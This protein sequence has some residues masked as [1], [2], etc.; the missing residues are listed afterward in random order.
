[1]SANVGFD[2][3]LTFINCQIQPS[4]GRS[5][6]P[7]AESQWRAIT[8]S[9]QTGSGA[10]VL[11]GQLADELQRLLPG[12]GRPWTVFDRNLVEKVLE[13][14]HLPTRLAQFM[15]EDRVP[16]M[17]DAIDELL[18]LHPSSWTLVRQTSETILRLV[19]LG[20]VILIG[21]GSSIVTRTLEH[22]LH[23]RLVAP[24]ARRVENLQKWRNL[25]H[26]AALDLIQR[27][28]KGRIRYVKTHFGVNI[29][30]PLLY[31][32][33]INTDMVNTDEAVRL[34]TALL[35]GRAEPA[36]AGK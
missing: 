27:E 13:D 1:M 16:E 3:C 15:P 22:V 28:D 21:R 2:K 35:V 4:T 25:T 32:M 19:D 5:S 33:V 36:Q 12:T 23:V 34:I 18:G 7:T 24:L 26:K 11:A 10:H 20:N 9:R 29:D 6:T 14:H 17:R 8:I 30:D 31:H